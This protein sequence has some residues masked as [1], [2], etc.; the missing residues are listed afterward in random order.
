MAQ[1]ITIQL[2]AAGDAVVI[3][4]TSPDTVNITTLY[5]PSISIGTLQGVWDTSSDPEKNTFVD[6]NDTEL[7]THVDWDWAKKVATLGRGGNYPLPTGADTSYRDGDDRWIEDNVF[8]AAVRGAEALKAKNSLV[9]HVT[10]KYT[11]EHGNLNRFTD[12]LG[13]QDY[14]NDLVEVHDLRVM[15]C[16]RI[17]AT[18]LTWN[19]CIDQALGSDFGGS[20]AE[21]GFNNWFLPNLNQAFALMKAENNGTQNHH[22]NFAPFN[23]ATSG[24]SF[25]SAIH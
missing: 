14:A 9:D 25:I 7:L 1:N 2:N 3:D 20:Q 6:A 17:L 16:R 23:T 19:Q 24:S 11:N 13:G 15:V 4:T 12:T 10:L 21:G 5:T 18:N 22:W 8:T